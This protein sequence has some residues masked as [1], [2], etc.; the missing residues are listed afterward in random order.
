LPTQLAIIKAQAIYLKMTN[1]K[2]FNQ[3]RR[4]N[5]YIVIDLALM[6]LSLWFFNYTEIDI[7]I[8]NYFFNFDEKSWIVDAQEPIK[9]FIFYNLP[10][11]ILGLAIA[12][13]LVATI[14]GFKNKN[15]NRHRFFVIFLGLSLIPLIAGNVK[16]FTNIYCPNQLEIYNGE[17]P[18]VKIL[19]PYS[20]DFIQEKRGNCFP[21]AHAVTGFAL[22]ILFFAFEKTSYR[23]LGFTVA[24][25]LGWIF[26]FYQMFKG[27]HFFSDSLISMLLCFLL[28]ALVTKLYLLKNDKR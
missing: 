2:I 25:A 11:I 19:E 26:A 27:V 13:F 10:K 12:I 20:K 8:Q 9:K 6:A 7:E 16:K 3:H 21:A 1:L 17:Y 28:A 24:F 4:I 5:L 23:V 15:K 18:Y 22:F 14:L